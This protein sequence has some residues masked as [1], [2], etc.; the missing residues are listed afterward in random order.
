MR[1]HLPSLVT[2]NVSSSM[3]WS[4]ASFKLH[5]CIICPTIEQAPSARTKSS[6]FPLGTK[7]R[8]TFKAKARSINWELALESTMQ[9]AGKSS[10][11]KQDKVSRS[12]D[13]KSL[14]IDTDEILNAQDKAIWWRALWR[15]FHE[16]PTKTLPVPSITT[17][18][19]TAKWEGTEKETGTGLMALGCIL[20]LRNWPSLITKYASFLPP[21]RVPCHQEQGLLVVGE[22]Y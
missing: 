4:I 20:A 1:F 16:I 6:S 7:G 10:F 13:P 21:R 14:D 12:S 2:W 11:T 19:K 3:C 22:E 5:V 15:D 17:L 8:F 9:V 18:S